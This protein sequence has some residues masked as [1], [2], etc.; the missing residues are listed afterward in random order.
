MSVETAIKTDYD[1]GGSSTTGAAPVE[2]VQQPSI[3]PS[4]YGTGK[5]KRVVIRAKVTHGGENKG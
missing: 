2:K 5:P 3:E 1:T 4:K